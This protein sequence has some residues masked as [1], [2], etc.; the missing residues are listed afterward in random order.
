ML[1][2]SMSRESPDSTL[3]LVVRR[4]IAASPERLFE[5]WTRPQEL[6]QWWGPAGVVCSAAEIDLRV[7]GRYRIGNQF[8]DGRLVWIVGQFQRVEPPRLLKYTWSVDADSPNPEVVTVRFEPRP[9]GTEVTVIHERISAPKLRDQH[10]QGWM[11]CLDGLGRYMVA[12][13]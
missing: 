3:V 11:G 8:P 13:G 7:G 12:G 5:A 1:W 2:L 9:G 6:R 10:E 4:M